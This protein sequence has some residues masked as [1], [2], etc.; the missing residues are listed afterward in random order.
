MR[1]RNR[2]LGVT[3]IE[4]VVAMTFVLICAA[5]LADSLTFS[6]QMIDYNQRRVLVQAALESNIDE[7]RS[8]CLTALPADG[9]TTSNFTL[10]GS[11]TVTIT[12]VVAKVSGKNL[13]QIHFTATWPEARGSRSF[14]DS[15]SFEIYLRGPDA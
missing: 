5:T 15:M 7:C 12:R 3:Y 9:T 14:T 1:L 11:R 6:N 10:G 8:T 4:I 13:A 2:R